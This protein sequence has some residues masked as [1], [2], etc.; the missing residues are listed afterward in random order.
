[1]PYRLSMLS[2]R[3]EH[4]A[5][6]G[7]QAPIVIRMATTGRIPFVEMSKFDQQ[8]CR[9]KRVQAAVQADRF[10][11]VLLTAAMI[12]DEPDALHQLSIGADHRSTVAV[13]PQIPTWI[14]A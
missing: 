7:E 12:G 8:N 1:M 13:C 6:I 4:H 5:G 2:D 10:M 3:G 14:Q 11:N 9:L